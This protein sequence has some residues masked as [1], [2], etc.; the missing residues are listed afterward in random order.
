LV[1][2]LA[3]GACGGSFDEEVE[4]LLPQRSAPPRAAAALPPLLDD[5]GA[6]QAA[7]ASALPQRSDYQTRAG[8]YA[9]R[10]QAEA[11]DRALGGAVIWIDVECCTDDAVETALGVV[12]G[13]AAARDLGTTAPVFVTGADLRIAAAAADR[14][15]VH[16]YTRTFLVT[17]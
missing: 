1:L 17:Q 4:V 5:A 11:L 10:A 13:L 7:L 16:G 9:L 6:P 8:L 12:A 15:G 14:L 3:L 2:A